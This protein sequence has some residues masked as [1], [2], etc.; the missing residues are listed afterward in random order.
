MR[1]MKSTVKLMNE[2]QVLKILSEQAPV[3]ACIMQD[4][5]FRY[6]NPF[7]SRATGYTASELVGRDSLAIVVPQDR[8]AVRESTMDAARTLMTVRAMCRNSFPSTPS[9]RKSVV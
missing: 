8:D 7:F 4:G 2:E 6:I 1:S 3:G 9:D 5:K